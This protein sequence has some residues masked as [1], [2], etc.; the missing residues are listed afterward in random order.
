MLEAV[1]NE[2]VDSGLIEVKLVPN[3]GYS[4]VA[5]LTF[6]HNL[7]DFSSASRDTRTFVA[8]GKICS[9]LHKESALSPR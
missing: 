8:A 6:R 2:L 5:K 3:D 7:N 9:L 1:S 4:C